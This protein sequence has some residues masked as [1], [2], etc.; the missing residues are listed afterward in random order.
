MKKIFISTM[1]I[2]F[3]AA[4]GFAQDKTRTLDVNG[5][6]TTLENGVTYR[7][8]PEGDSKLKFSKEQTTVSTLDLPVTIT[9]SSQTNTGGGDNPF[10]GSIPGSFAIKYQST[11]SM[12]SM[13]FSNSVSCDTYKGDFSRTD[14]IGQSIGIYDHKNRT[15]KMYSFAT[16]QWTD[17]TYNEEEANSDQYSEDDFYEITKTG[18]TTII[19]VVCDTYTLKLKSSDPEMDGQEMKAAISREW[20]IMMRTEMEITMEGMTISSIM[21]ALKYTFDVPDNAFSTS[22]LSPVWLD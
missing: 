9:F 7:F 8:A 15:A 21:T 11:Q 2:L 16:N 22:T 5:S 12:G 4:T 3:A 1:I 10:S 19:G 17:V 20:G 6:K 18:E 14:V 13:Q